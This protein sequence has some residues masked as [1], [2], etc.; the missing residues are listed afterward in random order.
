MRKG[1]NGDKY[2][3]GNLNVYYTSTNPVYGKIT[4][5]QFIE[6]EVEERGNY[7]EADVQRW[8][9]KYNLFPNDKVIWVSPKKWVANRY[10]LLAEEW[11]T[12]ENVPEAEMSVYEI[13]YD[14]GFIIPESDD[15]DEGYIFVYKKPINYTIREAVNP[16]LS[17]N[18]NE[19]IVN[20]IE[21]VKIRPWTIPQKRE[22][23]VARLRSLSGDIDRKIITEIRS[24][25]PLGTLSEFGA[26]MGA[27]ARKG[28]RIDTL[29]GATIFDEKRVPSKERVDRW[30]AEHKEA[31]RIYRLIP[32]YA[33]GIEARPNTVTGNFR[34]VEHARRLKNQGLLSKEEEL[35]LN[36]LEKYWK[37]HPEFDREKGYGIWAHN[38]D[39]MVP[40]RQKDKIGEIGMAG[41]FK[42]YF[43]NRPPDIGTHPKGAVMKEAWLPRKVTPKGNM[44]F[45]W[46]SYER[47]LTPEEIKSY[48]LFLDETVM[49]KLVA[50][51]IKFTHDEGINE[52]YKE[53]KSEYGKAFI[54]WLK[55]NNEWN[56]DKGEQ[57]EFL[58]HLA[59]LTGAGV[60]TPETKN[61]DQEKAKLF[62]SAIPRLT[63]DELIQQEATVRRWS[64]RF[65]QMEKE[66]EDEYKMYLELRRAEKTTQEAARKEKASKPHT[67][68]GK[69]LYKQMRKTNSVRELDDW[70]NRVLFEN[71]LPDVEED[72]LL[73]DLAAKWRTYLETRGIPALEALDKL[74]IDY[75][76]E[77]YYFGTEVWLH[78]TTTIFNDQPLRGKLH[79]A[80]NGGALFEVAIEGREG[81]QRTPT[82]R[83][84]VTKVIEKPEP[85]YQPP[86]GLY[87][88]KVYEHTGVPRPVRELRKVYDNVTFVKVKE[89]VESNPN[90]DYDI[91]D[92]QNNP[93]Q[94]IKLF[95]KLP[96]YTAWSKKI[97]E[98]RKRLEMENIKPPAKITQ[99]SPLHIQ[100]E[101]TEALYK[102]YTS[103]YSTISFL[104]IVNQDT[105]DLA[106]SIG[107]ELKLNTTIYTTGVLLRYAEQF[108]EL[109][110]KDYEKEHQKH[111]ARKEKEEAEKEKERREGGQAFWDEVKNLKVVD[112]EVEHDINPDK[113]TRTYYHV[114]ERTFAILENGKKVQISYEINKGEEGKRA[115][116]ATKE[117]YRKFYDRHIGKPLSE[118][119]T[120]HRENFVRTNMESYR[121]QKSKPRFTFIPEE[122]TP[123]KKGQ[124][125]KQ[126]IDLRMLRQILNK[127]IREPIDPNKIAAENNIPST[128]VIGMIEYKT[129][130]EKGIDY[131]Y[132]QM[133]K[134]DLNSIDEWL[135]K[136]NHPLSKG[137]S[138]Q[139]YRFKSIIKTLFIPD[140]PT[141]SSIKPTPLVSIPAAKPQSTQ[142]IK[143]QYTLKF[144]LA[145]SLDE[146]QA[147][148][149]E[150]AFLPISPADK[151]QLIDVFSKRYA[152]FTREI[153][154]GTRISPKMQEKARILGA[155]TPQQRFEEEQR[156]KAAE[157]KRTRG[158]QKLTAV[159]S[160]RLSEFGIKEPMRRYY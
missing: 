55:A 136:M 51:L 130:G 70:R 131:T 21:E 158:Q 159:G 33:F 19:K 61:E 2:M 42:Y 25:R 32:E 143:Q 135:I 36:A 43:R 94:F 109:A 138:T 87:T 102:R 35:T 84:Y 128:I 24:F 133:N 153:P 34:V 100:L 154:F 108:K 78:P 15:G 71:H 118:W 137:T 125:L 44:A 5:N 47:E 74:P 77:D 54:D 7:T 8:I 27:E 50:E 89:I 28:V 88:V 81:T 121:Y 4:F 52:G 156:R 127:A 63:L 14:E 99:P 107:F 75:K 65:P 144:Q 145:K 31:E 45:G 82:E 119:V 95:S 48:E 38:L 120:E 66:L 142:D 16:G 23:I 149:N 69:E 146:L 157:E 29:I 85:R 37:E 103:G 116:K 152:S 20:I 26:A 126:P 73:R 22:E 98:A 57:A 140:Q 124:V 141:L 39:I 46:V 67:E 59:R 49:P 148:K 151:T 9:I 114:Y 132:R 1:R 106:H 58:R 150:I 79:Q 56:P 86:K 10:N 123:Q 92:P 64:I 80:L 110:Q 129:H 12:A 155:Q 68:Q 76:N 113:P 97:D 11:D 30:D 6:T 96:D 111:L 40:E 83:I 101:S 41:Q 134:G 60:K 62:L 122:T 115:A 139:E 104:G 105:K 72:N 18:K 53:L 13:R 91:F 93:I 112:F 17:Q 160:K 3:S 90:Y 147:I 117:F